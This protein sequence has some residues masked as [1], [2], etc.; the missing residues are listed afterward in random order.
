MIAILVVI[1]DYAAFGRSWEAFRDHISEALAPVLWAMSLIVIY[2]S[3]RSARQLIKQIR[4][5]HNAPS[6]IDG[7][8]LTT[9]GQLNRVTV[10]PPPLP[11]LFRLKIWGA[12]AALITV[13]IV[14]STFMFIAV[15]GRAK[16]SIEQATAIFMECHL[17]RLPLAVPDGKTI[18]VIP[19][20]PDWTK[21]SSGTWFYEV[22]GC[23]ANGRWPD[24]RILSA[25]KAAYDPG[26]A[27]QCRISN[28]GPANLVYIQIPIDVWFD[29][30]P[31]SAPVKYSP[32]I[33]AVDSGKDVDFYIVNNSA[34]FVSAAWQQLSKC[35]VLGESRVREITLLPAALSPLEQ[36]MSFWPVH[37]NLL[38]GFCE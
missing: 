31:N 35:Q 34:A 21:N 22:V 15:Y 19:L 1:Y 23:P 18:K 37:V 25:L 24:N 12:A 9:S 13:L 28:H 17:V 38:A 14:S 10:V 8:I 32:I 11:H 5:E 16:G 4:L 2:H 29:A 6:E 7:R 3:I 36:M 27:Y 33:S 20:Q 26:T 30:K